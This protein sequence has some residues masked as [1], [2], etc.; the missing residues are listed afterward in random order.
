MTLLSF[1]VVSLM[2]MAMMSLGIVF[3]KTWLDKRF[4]SKPP[5]KLPPPSTGA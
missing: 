1:I 4:A 5:V 3:G 2:N